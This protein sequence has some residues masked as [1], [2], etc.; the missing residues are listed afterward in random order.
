MNEQKKTLILNSLKGPSDSIYCCYLLTV[1][2]ILKQLKMSESDWLG[3]IAPWCN[4]IEYIMDE[5]STISSA[6]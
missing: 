6:L 2:L 1:P 4:S 3:Q 5:F